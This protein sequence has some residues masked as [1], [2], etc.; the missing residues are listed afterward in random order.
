MRLRQLVSSSVCAATCIFLFVG[1]TYKTIVIDGVND[2]SADET[3][4]GTSGSTWY[5]TWDADNLYVG[6]LNSDVGTNSGT[7]W[8]LW[9][10]D[11]D[12]QLTPAEG[13]GTT[14]GVMYT[15]QRPTLPF[16]ANYHLRW[17][18]DGSY[19][20]LQSFNGTTWQSGDQSGMLQSRVGNYIEIKIPR[21]N[22]GSPG[23]IYICAAMISEA[24]GSEWTYFITPAAQSDGYNPAL[25]HFFGF[26]LDA[27]R[28]PNDAAYVDGPLPIQLTR[29]NAFSLSEKSVRLEW[30]T[31]SEIDN[32]GFE[33][34]RRTDGNTEYSAVPGGFV[35]G[36]GTTAS[37]HEYSFIDSS[38]PN[39]TLSYRLRQIDLDG[40]SH[41]TQAVNASPLS[42]VTDFGRPAQT[43]LLQNYPN[44]FNPSTKIG[45]RV[46][47]EKNGSGG[48]GLGSSNVKLAVYDLLGRKV[49][50]LV[51][52]QKQPGEYTAT[53]DATGMASGIYFYRLTVGEDENAFVQ[54]RQMLLMQ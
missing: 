11:T 45:F 40:T 38:A 50:V 14:A 41:F 15:T 17:K 10:I 48:W 53:W 21:S 46:W 30:A 42:G 12:P 33:V 22:I 34:Q 37:K 54:T 43:R 44:P 23:Q 2:F 52:E 24:P 5:F 29:F 47:G 39:S 16:S 36:H 27:G 18:G 4:S 35:P 28:S 32:Y 7:K 31:A 20:N 25:A 49:A 13:T 19:Y 6:A 9:Y 51:D 8:L 3:L 1:T 26:T